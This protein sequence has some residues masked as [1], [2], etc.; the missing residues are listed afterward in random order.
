MRI[1]PKQKGKSMKYYTLSF[2]P[3]TTDTITGSKDDL[4]A[5]LQNLIEEIEDI[6]EEITTKMPV[7]LY[8][9]SGDE[10]ITAWIEEQY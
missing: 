6:D 1:Q 8:D 2:K 7:N 10:Y 5:E 9:M 3:G 4:I